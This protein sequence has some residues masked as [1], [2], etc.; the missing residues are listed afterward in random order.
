M[1]YGCGES[2]EP[3]Q[4]IFSNSSGGW[5]RLC[6]QAL[7]SCKGMT[8]SIQQV[9]SSMV[10]PGL[11]FDVR[12]SVGGCPSYREPAKGTSQSVEK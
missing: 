4:R 12:S 2:A 7:E 11:F 1:R 5:D 10:T 8:L 9:P 3:G 6:A